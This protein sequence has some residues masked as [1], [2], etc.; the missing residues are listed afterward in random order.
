MGGVGAATS[1]ALLLGELGLAAAI[2]AAFNDEDLDVVG[3]AVDPATAA[4]V[5]PRVVRLR[6]DPDAAGV[7]RNVLARVS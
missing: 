7:A 5:H 3:Q 2:A 6:G 4:V 1:F